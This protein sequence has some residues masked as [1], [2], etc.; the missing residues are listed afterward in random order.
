M[1]KKLSNQECI[2][3]LKSI[4]GESLDYSKVDYKSSRS[5]ITLI[6][7]IHG[8]FQQYA[9]NALQGRGGCPKCKLAFSNR[10]EFIQNAK[11]IHGDKY[12]YSKVEYINMS[13]P[14]VIICPKHGEFKQTPRH[15][16]INGSGCAKCYHE[17]RTNNSKKQTISKEEKAIIRRNTWINECSKIHNNKYDY[18]KVPNLDSLNTK[19][20]I[21]CPIHGEFTQLAQTHKKCGCPK[22]AVEYRASQNMLSFEEFVNRANEIHHG[23]YTYE[24]YKGMFEKIKIKCSKHGYFEMTAHNHLKGNGCPICNSSNGERLIINILEELDIPYTAQH[25]IE[26]ETAIKKSNYILVDFFILHNNKKIFIEYNG[27]QHYE[28]VPFFHKGGISDF[29]IQQ[30]RD[31]ILRDYCKQNDITLLEIPYTYSIEEINKLIKNVL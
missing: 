14:V 19:V 16:V 1:A 10:E 5:Y 15:H 6:C 30:H 12:D 26:F 22:C 31:Q 11:E 7:P 18:S 24:E 17:S 8:E 9:N 25:K 13:T 28:Y 4:Y 2:N 23:I 3:K 27:I 29:N 21:I 20:P